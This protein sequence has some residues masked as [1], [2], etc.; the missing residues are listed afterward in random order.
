[1][2]VAV[3][4]VWFDGARRAPLGRNTNTASAIAGDGLF[5]DSCARRYV[6]R[7]HAGSLLLEHRVARC[8]WDAT[9]PSGVAVM[10]KGE[11]LGVSG[12]AVCGLVWACP[13][14]AVKIVVVR[15]VELE[16]M[17]DVWRA[18]GGDV[19]LLTLTVWH[20]REDGFM[21]NLD[22]FMVCMRRLWSGRWGQAFRR[23]HGIVGLVRNL[24]ITWG[25]ENGWHPHSHVLFF[26]DPD[27]A[28][29]IAPYVARDELSVRWMVF[30]VDVG[31]GAD[32]E[33]GVYIEAEPFAMDGAGAGSEH[34]AVRL[35][36]YAVKM[37]SAETGK[38]WGPV[39][40][41]TWSHIKRARG[42]R[43][44]PWALLAASIKVHDGDTLDYGVVFLF[45]EFVEAFHRRKQ[46]VGLVALRRLL[47]L[48]DVVE[49][50]ALVEA[51]DEGAVEVARIPVSVWR[52]L[53]VHGLVPAMLSYGETCGDEGLV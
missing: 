2:T 31:L 8:G 42:E 48:G 49:D 51:G 32:D 44:T 39:Q 18:Q 16:H 28:S 33:Y 4:F 1:M 36:R 21:V 15:A 10:R 20:G 26:V 3:V 37:A 52:W 45:M 38:A 22:V 13:V 41:L 17:I 11:R 9:D 34:H 6:L 23:R 30:M 12:V 7:D 27:A 43:F 50:E 46:L 24:E 35:A 53:R 25:V 47:H 29:I 14:C 40:E 19:W 5:T